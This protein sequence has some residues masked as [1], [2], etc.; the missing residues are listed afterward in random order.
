MICI[1]QVLSSN[2]G[3]DIAILTEIYRQFPQSLQA[4]VGIVPQLGQDR[5]LPNPT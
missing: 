2:L 3:R 1:R 5:V 4:N